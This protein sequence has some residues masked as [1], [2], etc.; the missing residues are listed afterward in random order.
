MLCGTR[1]L[2]LFFS[3]TLSPSSNESQDAVQFASFGE[4]EF[5][6]LISTHQNASHSAASSWNLRDQ[7]DF[8]L[9]VSFN[10][11]EKVSCVRQENFEVQKDSNPE[12]A[13]YECSKLHRGEQSRIELQITEFQIRD[14]LM[15]VLPWAQ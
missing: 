5:P 14:A 12:T 15:Y 9:I 7:I 10:K 11:I 13:L 6:L 8:M 1:F 4:L 2:T 3:Y